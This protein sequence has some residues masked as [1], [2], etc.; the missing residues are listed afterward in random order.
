M[1]GHFDL[2]SVLV[3]G[4]DSVL[5]DSDCE[6]GMNGVK[7]SA[8]PGKHGI[9]SYK[10]YSAIVQFSSPSIMLCCFWLRVH[11]SPFFEGQVS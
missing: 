11:H 1:T 8:R 4:F 6:V 2:S 5:V 10:K 7:I 3:L 9:G